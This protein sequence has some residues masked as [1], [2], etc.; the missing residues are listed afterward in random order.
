MQNRAILTGYLGQ[1]ALS[2]ITRNQTPYAVLSLATHRY[3]KDRTSG[4][5][6]SAT[7]WHRCIIFGNLATFAKKLRKGAFLHLEGEIRVREYFPS[8]GDSAK[9][10]ITEIRVFR[11]TSLDRSNRPANAGEVG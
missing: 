6:R 7:T 5:R 1:D 8:A 9:R 3:W 10:S 2:G 4:E 11:I